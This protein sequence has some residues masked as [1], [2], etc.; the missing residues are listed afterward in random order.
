MTVVPALQPLH[1]QAIVAALAS[2][3]FLKLLHPSIGDSLDVVYSAK[4]VLFQLILRVLTP[5]SV[6]AVSL[7]DLRRQHFPT[8]TCAPALFYELLLRALLAIRDPDA[9]GA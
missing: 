7:C 2:T 9:P 3:R 5:A 4:S 6:R 1:V 8:L